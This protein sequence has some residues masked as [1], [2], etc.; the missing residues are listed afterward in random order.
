MIKYRWNLN[1]CD[2]KLSSSDWGDF[3]NVNAKAG[4][5][6]SNSRLNK[7]FRILIQ[8]NAFSR[9]KKSSEYTSIY[10]MY[11]HISYTDCTIDLK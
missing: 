6:K 10:W 7:T 8:V 9:R 4:Q 11:S 1:K 3:S 2:L 5:S